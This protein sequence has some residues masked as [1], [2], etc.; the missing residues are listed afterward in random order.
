MFNAEII[1]QAQKHSMDSQFSHQEQ[2]LQFADYYPE[3]CILN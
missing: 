1:F 3:I 2:S